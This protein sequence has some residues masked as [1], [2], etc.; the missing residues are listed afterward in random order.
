MAS[1]LNAD[2]A[3]IVGQKEALSDSVIVRDLRSSTQ[4]DLPI[5]KAVEMI[6]TKYVKDAQDNR[7][8]C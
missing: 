8:C 5:K 7:D 6:K 2:Y 4:E 3:I 1:K